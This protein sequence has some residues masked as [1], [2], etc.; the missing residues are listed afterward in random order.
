MP[1]P[2]H[3]TASLLEHGTFLSALTLASRVLILTLAL[4][5]SS[6]AEAPLDPY[7]RPFN[8]ANQMPAGKK[9]ACDK[10]D[11]D[12]PARLLSGTLP[13]YPILQNQARNTG[14]AHLRFVVDADGR[15]K[16]VS[17]TSDA[18]PYFASH[19]VVATQDWKLSP[20][21]KD[22]KPVATTCEM[23]INYTIPK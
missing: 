1:G 17:A 4:A 9:L 13:M 2:V 19:A 8:P 10:N 7:G 20:A 3:L 18:S 15:L 6:C 21:K 5:T 23:V 22:G 16:D 11:A 14:K 12:E